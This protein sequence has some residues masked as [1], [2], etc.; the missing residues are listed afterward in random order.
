MSCV[1]VRLAPL[2][3]LQEVGQGGDGSKPGSETAIAS[4]PP[5]DLPLEEG[6]ATAFMGAFEAFASQVTSFAGG[7]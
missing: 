6:G 1:A 5:P 3:P 2:P 7:I 4:H